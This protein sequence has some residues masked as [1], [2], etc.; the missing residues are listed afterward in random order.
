MLYGFAD[1]NHVSIA[2]VH[3][4]IHSLL[5]GARRFAFRQPL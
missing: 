2:F 5:D 1:A 4:M 3:V